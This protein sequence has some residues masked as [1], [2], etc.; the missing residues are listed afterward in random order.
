MY[1]CPFADT[2]D[3]SVASTR[4]SKGKGR[5]TMFFVWRALSAKNYRRM[6]AQLN[7]FVWAIFLTSHHI[8][9]LKIN[10]CKYIIFSQF[11]VKSLMFLLWNNL[12]NFPANVY[13][14]FPAVNA[15]LQY[16]LLLQ[17]SFTNLVF[18][19]LI[20]FFFIFWL[21]T[22]KWDASYFFRSK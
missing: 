16:S 1:L 9:V 8:W 4:I 19:L 22:K 14:Y 7:S 5:Y 2:I 17:T 15:P 20:L 3:V 10:F 13:C 21:P 11:M 18:I 12:Y 6:E